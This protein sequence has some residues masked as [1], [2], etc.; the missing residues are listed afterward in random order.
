[1][2]EYHG[3][4]SH[5]EISKKNVTNIYKDPIKSFLSLFQ[6]RSVGALIIIFALVGFLFPTIPRIVTPYLFL[7]ALLFPVGLS[8]LA[9]YRPITS[10][11][12][13]DPYNIVP[14]KT[15]RTIGTSEGVGYMGVD[16]LTGEE[17][18]MTSEK[19][20]RH[21]L[22]LST[23]GGGK[24]VSLTSFTISFTLVMASGYSYTDGKAQLDL[25]VEHLGNAFRFNRA[26]DFLM[27][28]YITGGVDLWGVSQDMKS[29][30]FNPH[31]EASYSEISELH[32]SLLD[33]EKDVWGKRAISYSNAL[34]KIL[35][36][37][38]DHGEIEMSVESFIPYLALESTGKLAGR[39]DIPDVARS[40]LY[41]FIRTIPGMN[42]PSFNALTHGSP[43]K[44]TTIYDQFGYITMQIIPLLNML[45][46]DYGHIFKCLQG[47]VSMKDSVINRR[48][49]MILLPA[50][51]KSPDSL[52]NLG[53]IS[54][55]A[56]KS[57]MGS[58]L[59]SVF[60]GDVQK[61]IK[62]SATSALT[63]YLSIN[64]EVSYYFVEGT[65]VAA[66]Q[67]R[68]LFIAM[69]YCAQDLPGMR[70]LSE[71]ASKETD[72]VIGN[73]L[74]KL[75]G[76]LIDKESIDMFQNQMGEAWT[77][78]V[79][80]MDVDRDGALYGRHVANEVTNSRRNRV[81]V[82]DFN[83]LI[84][85]EA[86]LQHRDSYIPI[87]VP[88][89]TCDELKTTALNEFIP[90][91]KL[92]NARLEEL[93]YLTKRYHNAFASLPTKEHTTHITAASQDAFETIQAALHYSK[94]ANNSPAVHGHVAVMA[95][96]NHI[97]ELLKQ[98]TG[99]A[100]DYAQISGTADD[101][102]FVNTSINTPEVKASVE[103]DEQALGDE[104]NM[105]D[106]FGSDVKPNESEF[107]K[108]V[109]KARKDHEGTAQNI[110][111]GGLISE[112][113]LREDYTEIH[114]HIQPKAEKAIVKKRVDKTIE[115][116][117][118]VTGY[119]GSK[120]PIKDK[121]STLRLLENLKKD[122]DKSI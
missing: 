9:L 78:E 90:C 3:V 1:M 23:T 43:V 29:N 89:L 66:A 25:S 11:Q 71:M 54:L 52:A 32:I 100:P 118:E 79:N 12:R 26:I 31:S 70:R 20:R 35:V 17:I 77:T 81:D 5:S 48:I 94:Q 63:P 42:E 18:W 44:S 72:S 34:T 111:A 85:G 24:S 86:F 103:H 64:D 8:K 97:D 119:P 21:F 121:R 116:I 104:F 19:M 117:A 62:N 99:S 112:S 56:Q 30:T 61:N 37:M 46:G 115:N 88:M 47:Q 83:N 4:N 87:D 55:A 110:F 84:E 80:R 57:M 60:E 109:N 65:A 107:D 93:R 92:T 50:L 51:E 6:G 101:S 7:F 2:S 76:F 108:N 15:G 40:Q 58:S 98:F 102:A 113:Q 45:V 41:E 114:K 38:R 106:D 91:P 36:Y 27:V 16:R 28:S 95:F 14:S 22:Y 67:S 73:T 53:R 68:S 49:L 33:A 120:R 59:G 75:G 96:T 13:K 122:L 74:T 69:M 82:R 105:S 10:K 39:K